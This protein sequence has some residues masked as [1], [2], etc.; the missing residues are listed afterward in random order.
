MEKLRILTYHRAGIPRTAGYEHFTVPPERFRGQVRW[1]RL[2]GFGF[3]SLDDVLPWLAGGRAGPKRP[4]VLT[5]DDGYAEVYQ[6]AFPLL[7]ERRIPAVV[8]LVPGRRTD[9]WVDWEG[10]DHLPLMEWGHARE[11]AE[12]GITF[13]SHAMTHPRL[14]E[15]DDARLRAEVADSKKMIEDQLGRAV[16]HFCYPYGKHDARVVEAVRE[17]GYE[18]ACTTHKGCVLRGTDPFLL[19]RLT[20]GKRMGTRRFLMRLLIRH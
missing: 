16:R 2:L 11:M 8:F 19:P 12:A 5:F 13:G 18:T 14:P 1:M 3:C 17:A 7:L 9:D 4:V 15:C 6:H 10:E 20:V